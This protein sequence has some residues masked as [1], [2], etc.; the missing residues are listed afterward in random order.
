L[1]F[2]GPSL[3][4]PPPHPLELCCL[5]LQNTKKLK[6][7]GIPKK[8]AQMI[9]LRRTWSEGSEWVS[10]WVGWVGGF[11]AREQQR[12]SLLSH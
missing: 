8:E 1:V 10:E 2:V 5:L 4:P 11:N 6:K 12:L 9:D 3:P 7:N